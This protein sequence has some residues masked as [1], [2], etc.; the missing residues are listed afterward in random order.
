MSDNTML[1][2]MVRGVL[3]LVFAAVATWAANAI[4]E[5]M[6]GPEPGDEQLA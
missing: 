6:F 2:N 1:R 3:G 4:V 5:K